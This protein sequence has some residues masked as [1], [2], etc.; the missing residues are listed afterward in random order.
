MEKSAASS[1]NRLRSLAWMTGIGL[2]FGA[3][4]VLGQAVLPGSWNHFANS[5]AVWL[6]ASF[7][8]GW[9]MPSAA[10]AAAGGFVSLIG[11]LAGYTAV[12]TLLGLAYPLSTIAFWGAIALV[13]GPIFGLAGWWRRRP[14]D[15]WPHAVSAALMGGVFIAEGWYMLAVIQDAL[16]G[17]VSIAIGGLFALLLPR[18]WKAR[19]RSLAALVPIVLLGIAAYALL[20][21]LAS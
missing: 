11:A 18:T 20:A 10:W 16:S 14:A 17:W 6:I 21:R 3:L 13:G 7:L 2:L 19:S 8:V 5:G 15:A 9:R 12:I 4:T 1:Q